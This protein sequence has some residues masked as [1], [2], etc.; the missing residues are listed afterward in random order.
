MSWREKIY[1]GSFR[2]V[3]FNMTEAEVSKGK[4]LVIHQYPNKD[5]P[6]IEEMGKDSSQTTFECFVSGLDYMDRRDALDAALDKSGEGKLIHPFWGELIVKVSEYRIK[7]S[8]REKGVARFSIVFI[9]AGEN[10]YPANNI[11]TAAVLN[12]K[13]DNVFSVL[14]TDFAN[15]FNV[16]GLPSFVA[17]EAKT[18]TTG[19]LSL[20]SGMASFSGDVSAVDVTSAMQSPGELASVITTAVQQVG[21]VTDLRKIT[22]YGNTLPSVVQTTPSRAAQAKNQAALLRLFNISGVTEM[23][24]RMVD[25]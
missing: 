9:K 8:F 25:V 10:K 17:D 15:Q 18:I 22:R 1:Q 2:G 21:D 14:H 20:V 11:S 7:E 3:P 5:D 16:K 12:Q 13:A 19:G 4:R 24:R 23:A 6:Y